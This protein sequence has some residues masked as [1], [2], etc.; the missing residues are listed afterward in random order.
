MP[1]PAA[2]KRLFLERTYTTNEL[3]RLRNG[4][5][6]VEMED[7]RIKYFEQPWFYVHLSWTGFC[8]YA[9]RLDLLSDSGA[10][11]S[12][13]QVIRDVGQYG[14]TDDVEDGLLLAVLLDDLAGR[15]TDTAWKAYEA[16]ARETRDD[17]R[18]P[19]G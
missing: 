7:R 4:R 3:A 11:I 15:A 1:L 18:K 5:V 9:L 13:V 19:K 12:E 14:G 2:R 16:H 17:R 10:R 8:I 6:H